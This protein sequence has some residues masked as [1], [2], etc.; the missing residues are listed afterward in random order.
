MAKKKNP[1]CTILW[2]DA[3]YSFESEKPLEIPSPHLTT[4]FIIEAND[5]YAFIASNVLYTSSGKLLPI[6]GIIIPEKTTL[7][8][9]VMGNYNE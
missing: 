6:D 7:E 8:F 9:K 4:G 2:Q 1:V 3:A 5:D